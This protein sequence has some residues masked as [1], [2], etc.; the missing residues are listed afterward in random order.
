LPT[1]ERNWDRIEVLL[2]DNLFRELLEEDEDTRDEIG[3][4]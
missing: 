3:E 4:L 2:Q 1:F